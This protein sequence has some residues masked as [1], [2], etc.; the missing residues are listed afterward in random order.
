MTEEI[1]ERL[2][3]YLGSEE[4]EHE[5]ENCMEELDESGEGINA[6]L[7]LLR[8][9][10]RHPMADISMTSA[11]VRY[12]EQFYGRGYENILMDSVRRRPT[13]HT[14]RMLGR[15]RNAAIDE[16]QDGEEFEDVLIDV[17]SSEAEDEIK[18]TVRELI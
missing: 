3:E 12:M 2:E 11:V 6:V 9:L 15:L 5:A 4:F 16:G 1:I 10:E 7:P 17:L 14:V 8:F 13:V 18:D